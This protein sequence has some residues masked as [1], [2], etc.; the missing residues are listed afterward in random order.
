[1]QSASDFNTFASKEDTPSTVC[2]GQWIGLVG[3][4]ALL[5]FTWLP[6][7]YLLMVDWPYCLWWQGAFC[8]FI[9]Y[10]IWM[11]RQFSQS[12]TLLGYHLDWVVLLLLCCCI[13]SS[14]AAQFR[15]IAGWN[16]LLFSSYGIALYLLVNALRQSPKLKERLWLAL[17][18]TGT[19]THFISLIS[20]RPTADMWLS[21]SFHTAIRN[22]LPLGHHNFV[23][24]YCLLMLPLI[25]GFTLAQKGW[26]RWLGW[27]AIALN[28]ITL[29]ISGSRGALLGALALGIVVLPI[30][31]FCYPSK[32]RKHWIVGIL[33]ATLLT[34]ALI[35]NPRVRTLTTFNPSASNQRFSLEQISDGPTK[36]R[37]FMLQAGQRIV[38]AHPFLGVGPGNLSRVY[39]RYRPIEV[40]GGLDLVQQ[41]HNTPAQI[42]AEMGILGFIGYLFWV[43]ILVRLG[44]SIHRKV[45]DRSDRIL[46]YSIASSWFAYAVSSLTDYQ[47]ENIG[48]ATILLITTALLIAISDRYIQPRNIQPLSVRNRRF[49]SLFLFLY[50]SVA[51]QSWARVDAG[52]Y[53][54][55][56]AQNDIENRNVLHADAKW[57]KS[58][59]LIPWDPTP[60]V[61][62]AE[63]LT[64]I[65]EQTGDVE[66]K[67]KL[68]DTAI[69]SLKQALIAAP[70]DPWFNQNLAVLL[71]DQSPEDAEKYSRQA[72]LLA[73][74]SQ[75]NSYYTLGQIYLKQGKQKDAI[76]AFI[77]ESLT[78]PKF[79]VDPIWKAP[80]MT[81]LLEPVVEKTLTAWQQVL[82]DTAS[83]S[84]Q[85]AWL[86]QQIALIKWWYHRP[87]S[88]QTIQ[89][90][91]SY[92]QLILNLDNNAETTL[93]LLQQIASTSDS[94]SSAKLA[95]LSAWLAPDTY[96]NN[97]LE[98]FD[99]TPE[100]KRAVI[101][102]IDRYPDVRAWLTSVRQPM[103]ERLR[104]GLAFAYR[105]HAASR[106][107]QILVADG[108]S[109][110]YLLDQL[111]ILSDPPREFAQLDQKIAQLSQQS[112][113]INR[114]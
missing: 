59:Q 45:F 15:A 28:T 86:N 64:Y 6:N 21:Q 65:S 81:S 98:D 57:M 111:S 29:Y 46:L 38:K 54:T 113:A 20:W 67:Q 5:S 14:L 109:F 55:H 8:L 10:S 112:L 11:S 42:L 94:P 61:L 36:D 89:T 9:C 53:L 66:R 73:P 18:A 2:K 4:A 96:L 19:V 68:K 88:Q 24:G 93:S 3:L 60:S 92:I 16:V 75:H 91:T 12:L 7:S 87:L 41:L 39:N 43:A 27:G 32:T 85:Y 50:L 76:V 80:N 79:L 82:S 26:W 49:V 52:F 62:A 70:N 105:N 23:G 48:I 84:R 90:Q 104:F 77:L 25:V 69:D 63:Q 17:V 47:L 107:R 1:M 34:G 51:L 95:L 71:S 22:P 114:D 56:S 31:F 83:G 58:A 13:V 101:N 106:I 74:R 102:N 33:L 100:E 30:Y 72:V 44:L 103:P 97:A 35:S 110:S 78:N 108:L 37:L 40:G 99:A